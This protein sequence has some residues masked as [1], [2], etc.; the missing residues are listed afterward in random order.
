VLILFGS[1]V[2]NL[3]TPKT[4]VVKSAT[5]GWYEVRGDNFNPWSRFF[6]AGKPAAETVYVNSHLAFIRGNP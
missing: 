1:L 4:L 6:I 3:L 5:P 2:T